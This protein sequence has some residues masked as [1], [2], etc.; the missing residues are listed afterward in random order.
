MRKWGR[1][2]SVYKQIL[3]ALCIINLTLSDLKNELQAADR[4]CKSCAHD[5]LCPL[6]PRVL[7]P[8]KS[9]AGGDGTQARVWAPACGRASQRDSCEIPHTGLQCLINALIGN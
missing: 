3:N 7:R 1:Q 4:W 9:E 6:P 5:D 8:A 2:P